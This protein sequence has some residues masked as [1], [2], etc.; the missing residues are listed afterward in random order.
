MSVP[1]VLALLA[2][3]R[4][5]RFD[6]KTLFHGRGPLAQLATVDGDLLDFQV[7][8]SAPEIKALDVDISPWAP[9]EPGRS[10][11]T[12]FTSMDD[13]WTMYVLRCSPNSAD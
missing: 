1:D 4:S 11:L 6:I 2:P 8:F 5:F 3:F 13:G 10:L 9:E 12:D 7:A